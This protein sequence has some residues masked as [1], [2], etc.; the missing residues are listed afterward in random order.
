M[1]SCGITD[2]ISVQETAGE[3]GID[4]IIEML[5]NVNLANDL[6]LLANGGRVMVSRHFSSFM[7]NL[8]QNLQLSISHFPPNQFHARLWEAEVPLR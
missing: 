1:M 3:E 8:I 2:F 6:P 7:R 4:I 5:A